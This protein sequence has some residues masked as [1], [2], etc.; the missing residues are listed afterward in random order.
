MNEIIRNIEKKIEY[1]QY[2]L[3]SFEFLAETHKKIDEVLVLFSQ[4]KGDLAAEKFALIGRNELIKYYM[5]YLK[6]FDC[7]E[8]ILKKID[9]VDFFLYD[10]KNKEI[11]IRKYEMI[12][13]LSILIY[14]NKTE[15]TEEVEES[16]VKF[17]EYYS[18]IYDDDYYEVLEGLSDTPD[19]SL[20]YTILY[21][22]MDV[23]NYDYKSKNTCIRVDILRRTMATIDDSFHSSFIE[24]DDVRVDYTILLLDTYNAVIKEKI[25]GFRKELRK[26]RKENS[27]LITKL[28]KLMRINDKLGKEIISDNVLTGILDDSDESIKIL[29]SIAKSNS[30]I[31]KNTEKEFTIKEK[32]IY[33]LY[34]YHYNFDELSTSF[35]NNINDI[36]ADIL[37][38]NLDKLGSYHIVLSNPNLEY[39][40]NYNKLIDFNKLKPFIS[41]GII[42][43]FVLNNNVRLLT[44][45]SEFHNF[46]NNIKLFE[47]Y[48]VNI[49]DIIDRHFDILFIDHGYLKNVFD[50]YTSYGIKIDSNNLIRLV[51][52]TNLDI[53]DLFIEEGYGDFILSNLEFL[54]DGENIVKRIHINGLVETDSVYG[55]SINPD[56]L[57]E[58]TFFVSDRCLDDACSSKV[59]YF[60]DKDIKEILNNSFRNNISEDIA[61]SDI[62]LKLDS[63]Y[64]PNKL[65]VYLNDNSLLGV[66]DLKTISYEVK[67]L[68]GKTKELN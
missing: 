9:A 42:Y 6:F 54:E 22:Y 56:L 19:F 47:N 16:L 55:G 1:N 62:V 41:R 20:I 13:T 39:I 64:K 58:G 23:I 43:S 46:Y 34:N 11:R 17:K 2:L 67:C 63:N 21:N 36:D 65:Y 7:E 44:S 57:N 37:R 48:S 8:E 33:I 5:F 27:A 12:L 49:I 26:T 30:D 10:G 35:K 15:P 29:T 25:E 40:I 52:T 60:E 50:I 32:L 31:V 24:D 53:I 14:E 28:E 66:D 38:E 4:N 3:D 68:F 61:F 59:Y 51:D 45:D 18:R